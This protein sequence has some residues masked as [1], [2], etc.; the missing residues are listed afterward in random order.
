MWAERANHMLAA[1]WLEGDLGRQGAKMKASHA[2]VAIL[3]IIRDN[4][5]YSIVVSD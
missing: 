4:K 3:G 1:G 5:R 2:N